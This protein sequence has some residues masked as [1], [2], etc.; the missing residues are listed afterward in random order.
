MQSDSCQ[1]A[2]LGLDSNPG[3]PDE[4]TCGY[5]DEAKWPSCPY[6]TCRPEILGFVVDNLS[7]FADFILFMTIFESV[8][9]LINCLLICYNPRDNVEEMLIKAGTLTKKRSYMRRP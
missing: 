4:S 5:G 8:L 2:C 7:P 3:C 6:N 9:L 1:L